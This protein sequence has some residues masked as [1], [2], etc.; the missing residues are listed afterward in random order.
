MMS[1]YVISTIILSIISVL[2]AILQ[3]EEP[4]LKSHWTKRLYVEYWLNYI[5]V[6]IFSDI[7]IDDVSCGPVNICTDKV[8]KGEPESSA[9]KIPFKVCLPADEKGANKLLRVNIKFKTQS[10]TTLRLYDSKGTTIQDIV[11]DSNSIGTGYQGK[12]SLMLVPIANGITIKI[13]VDIEIYRK[14]NNQTRFRRSEIIINGRETNAF[15]TKMK[16]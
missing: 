10:D 3:F 12:F 16:S 6:Y 7:S 4:L 15:E 1:P 9:Y 2:F 5:K 13:K 14:Q 11:V 8:D